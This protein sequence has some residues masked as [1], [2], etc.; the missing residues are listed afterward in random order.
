MKTFRHFLRLLFVHCDEIAR[1][2]SAG[3]D[4]KLPRHERVAVNIH[5]AY[6]KACRRYRRQV[7]LLRTAMTRFV[8]DVK[9]DNATTIPALSPEARDRLKNTLRQ[10]C[11]GFSALF[12]SM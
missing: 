6:C 7:L 1:L 11:I 12:F 4:G 2:A 5:M 9:N 8:N 10:L 3:M